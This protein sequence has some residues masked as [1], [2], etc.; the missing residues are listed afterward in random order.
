M[1]ILAVLPLYALM[2][3]GD[4]LDTEH[5]TDNLIEGYIKLLRLF[6]IL[7]VVNM[8]KVRASEKDDDDDDDDP[9]ASLWSVYDSI[10]T[11]CVYSLPP[12]LKV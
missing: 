7:R 4:P 8:L 3:F 2:V 10:R 5:S 9:H 12:F 11:A 1:E 6:R